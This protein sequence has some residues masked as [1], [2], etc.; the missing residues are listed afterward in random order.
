[1]NKYT[2]VKVIGV[3]SEAKAILVKK[4]DNDQLFVIKQRTF[5]TLEDANEGLNEA[6]SLAKFQHASIVRFEEVFIEKNGA[7]HNLCIV[8]EYC[9]G[10]D[11]MEFMINLILAGMVDTTTHNSNSPGGGGPASIRCRDRDTP[12]PCAS[13][14]YSYATDEFETTY[15]STSYDSSSS[16]S[17]LTSSSSYLPSP[18]MSTASTSQAKTTNG[19]SITIPRLD[20]V[21]MMSPV[22]LSSPTPSTPDTPDEYAIRHAS[23]EQQIQRIQQQ[24]NCAP[25]HLNIITSPQQS[26]AVAPQMSNNG[27]QRTPSPKKTVSK[28]TWFRKSKGVK[29]PPKEFSI[30]SDEVPVSPTSPSSITRSSGEKMA[31]ILI[32]SKILYGWIYQLCQAVQSIH[33]SHVIHRDLKSE[34]IF[35]S[36]YKVKIGDFGLATRFENPVKGIAGTYYYS[37]PEIL[38]NN[39][40][41][42]PADIFSLGCII[43]EMTTLHLLPLTKR[44][45]AEELLAGTF[46]PSRFRRE[47][48]H[49]H[50]QLAEMVLKMLDPNPDSRPSIDLVLQN[51]IFDGFK[52]KSTLITT[53]PN[54]SPEIAASLSTFSITFHGGVR[55]QLDRSELGRAAA[56][57][58]EAY[59]MDP[60]FAWINGLGTNSMMN[61][62]SSI[63]SKQSDCSPDFEGIGNMNDVSKDN[64]DIY[65]DGLNIRNI[66]FTAAL[67]IMF[68][69]GY[70][71]WGYYNSQNVLS[72]V[73]CWIPPNAS[74]RVPVFMGKLFKLLPKLGIRN[75]YRI[76]KLMSIVNC[77]LMKAHAVSE[78][79][80]QY[81]LAYCGVTK[82]SRSKGIGRYLLSPVLEWSDFANVGCKT[83]VM[84]QRSI[85]FFMKMGFEMSYEIKGSL[86]PKGMEVVWVME[87]RPKPRAGN[88][89][90]EPGSAAHLQQQSND[91]EFKSLK[92]VFMT[93]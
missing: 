3:G 51:K 91:D 65:D 72:G 10:G 14:P 63:T 83:L 62:T 43:Y 85:P 29:P 9:D 74:K 69:E 27:A 17:S 50:L 36:D 61:D 57:L 58:A 41:C 56:V 32:P 42:R 33:N 38:N 75:A 46:D 67:H 45:I 37:S 92:H 4:N 7:T 26:P 60:R 19:Q 1:M 23:R 28:P 18:P 16:S 30:S 48:P 90:C 5:S 59:R 54:P 49:E 2:V 64:L 6:M 34:N 77:V 68:K 82:D 20:Q 88:G 21:S 81:H 71:I 15:D 12:P 80:H 66:F 25:L 22:L 39:S 44:C 47:F 87:R 78:Q 70:I 52:T 13:P 76:R 35:L 40:Y 84:K 79:P 11:L 89:V 55:K 31:R 8:M 24:Y 53:K 86:L 73:A 93:M